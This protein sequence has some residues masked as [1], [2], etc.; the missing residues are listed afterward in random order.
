MLTKRFFLACLAVSSLSTAWADESPWTYR[1]GVTNVAFDAS[2][3]VYLDGHRVPGGSADASDNNALTFDIG[4]D[5]TDLWNVRFIFGVPPTTKVTG[6]GSLPGMQ[7]GKIKYAPAVLT[8]NFNLPSLGP[9]RPHIGAG[10]NYTRIVASEDTNLKS[11]DA[12]HAWPPALQVGADIDVTNNWF[13][14][15]D[16]RKLFLKTDASGYLG[17]Q[18]AKAKVTLDPLLTSLAIGYR[19]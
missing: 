8:L 14:S 10:V 1:V 5:I 13:V 15:I 9:I 11:F 12:D 16:I 7:L 2:A 17:P 3:K 18:E 4:Y 6:A 19:F